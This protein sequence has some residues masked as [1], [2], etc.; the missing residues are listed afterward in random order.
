[1]NIHIC[2]LVIAVVLVIAIV[3]VYLIAR[4]DNSS[5]GMGGC[6]AA[7]IFLPLAVIVT[8]AT[9]LFHFVNCVGLQT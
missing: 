1:M 7:L 2:W 5:F 6:L 8:L 4:D 9:L 3:W